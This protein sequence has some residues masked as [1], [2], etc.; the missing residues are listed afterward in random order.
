M[1]DDHSA[2]EGLVVKEYEFDE[3]GRE[4]RSKIISPFFD[5]VATSNEYIYV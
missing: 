2:Y 1:V 4:I 5:V 3:A